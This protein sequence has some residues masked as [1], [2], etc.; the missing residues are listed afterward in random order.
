MR[1][2]G[3]HFALLALVL[4]GV[5]L[6]TQVSPG[7]AQTA[8]E[9][10]ALNDQINERKAEIENINKKLDEYRA[11]I[12][13]YASKSASL[14]TDV[15]MI[16]NQT[17]LA[18]LNI[19]ATQAEIDTQ[20]LALSVVE[21]RVREES[22]R[23]ERE[24]AMLGT[25]LFSLNQKENQGVVTAVL[26]SES[27]HEAFSS[28]AQLEDVNRGV[29]Q[30][31]EATKHTRDGLEADKA[32]H[33]ERLQALQT[34]AQD[35]EIR[36]AK[37]DATKEAKSILLVQTASSEGEY[38]TLVSELRQ[39]QAAITSQINALESE[40]TQK[41]D[42]ADLTGDA[43][44]LSWPLEGIITATFHDPTY[45][46]R[47]LFPHSGLD[48][49]VPVG[50]SVGSAAPAIVARTG[51]GT[52]YG[53]YVVLIHSNGISTLYAHLMSINVVP[54]EFVMRGQQI[55]LSGGRPGMQG[56]GLSTG[57][58]LHFEVRQEGIPV[59]PLQYLVE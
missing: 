24:R 42:E 4:G 18:E 14:A 50:T 58:H 43:S 38:R 15:A 9:V 21:A 8:E 31:L 33:E 36:V 16:E 10:S 28:I 7:R 25:L 1:H 12:K 20:T 3:K 22:E 11:R 53:N 6:F 46:F 52:S 40:V 34:L 59:D 2:G 5:F 55:G 37:L 39:E 27:F 23:L 44:V 45:P 13:E 26:G 32:E 49:A 29:N 17:A 30:A 48:I 51:T 57:P 54:E 35:L 56:A 41:I 19:A 47:N